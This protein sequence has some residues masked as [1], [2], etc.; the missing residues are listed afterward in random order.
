MP[1]IGSTRRR[2]GQ[3][4]SLDQL[5]E[6]I[7]ARVLTSDSVRAEHIEVSSLRGQL[8]G[9]SISSVSGEKITLKSIAESKLSQLLQDKINS[10]KDLATQA[11]GL[12]TFRFQQQIDDL[13]GALAARIERAAALASSAIQPGAR[14]FLHSLK[15]NTAEFGFTVINSDTSITST[16]ATFYNVSTG[17]G[18]VTITLPSATTCTGLMLG[19]NKTLSANNMILD[20]AASQ[21]INGSTTK[22]YGS[23][24]D[25]V[26]II[27][28]GSNWNI[29]SNRS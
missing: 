21:T 29:I 19:F 26:V 2:R 7:R 6:E 10:A 12:A 18:D 11:I 13:E 22:S 8:P 23:Q 24:Y 17:S 9:S 14:A 4:Y 20:G 25:A 5:S 27:S 28:N 1:R 3:D 16:Q 15:A